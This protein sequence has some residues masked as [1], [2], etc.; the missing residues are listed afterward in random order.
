VLVGD[1]VADQEAARAAGLA[2]GIHVLTGHG[3]AHQE[4]ARAM[5]SEEFPVHIVSGAFDAV[6]LLQFQPQRN[7]QANV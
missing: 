7:N 2:Y 1:K 6:P 5:D 4:A 3:Q